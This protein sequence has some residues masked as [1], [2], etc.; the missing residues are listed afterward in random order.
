MGPGALLLG[1]WSVE[2]LQIHRHFRSTQR[3]NIKHTSPILSEF[4]SEQAI[5]S[6]VFTINTC[7]IPLDNKANMRDVKRKG[8]SNEQQTRRNR[9]HW[10]RTVV[11]Q[12]VGEGGIM[13]KHAE[14]G[15][16]RGAKHPLL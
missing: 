14:L 1:V 12:K 7:Y 4:M 3:V 8:T 5:S 10:E 9:E 6:S 15:W 13:P 16:G 11:E 2:D